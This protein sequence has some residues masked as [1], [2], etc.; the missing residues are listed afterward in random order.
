MSKI[1]QLCGNPVGDDMNFCQNCGTPCP[2]ITE[3]QQPQQPVFQQPQQPV[4]QPRESA[5][6][7]FSVFLRSVLERLKSDRGFQIFCF[8]GLAAL[9]VVV[10]IICLIAGSNGYTKPLDNLIAITVKGKASAIEKMA[11]AA[12]WDWYEARNNRSVDDLIDEYKDEW[13][14]TLDELEDQ[15]GDNVRMHYEVLRARDLKDRTLKNIAQILE[16]RYDIPA[17]SVTDGKEVSVLMTI[18][19]DDEDE[20]WA[21]N[22]MSCTMIKI[23]GAWYYIGYTDSNAWFII[24]N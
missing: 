9:I 13:E 12:Y 7:G 19:G 6:S 14:D 21:A 1:C 22:V 4:Q 24:G 17:K 23:K 16:D 20:G 18:E 3:P 8:G 2:T 5:P 11:P 10:V 15:F